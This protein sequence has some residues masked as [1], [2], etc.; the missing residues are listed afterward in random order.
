[1]ARG[2]RKTSLRFRRINL[3]FDRLVETAVEEHRV[4]VAAGAPLRG[5]G[6]DRVLHVLDRLAVPLIVERREMTRR[7]LPLFVDI[8]MAPAAACTGHEKVCWS[9]P[10]HV[11][12]ARRSKHLP[13]W[14]PFRL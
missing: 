14:T 6:A 8:G 13:R 7:R 10:V 5:F 1:M 12:L 9:R 2:A 11:R 3:F 4:V